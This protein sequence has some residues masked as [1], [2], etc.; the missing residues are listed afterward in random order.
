MQAATLLL[1]DSQIRN[2][3]SKFILAH[4][5]LCTGIFSMLQEQTIRIDT[6]IVRYIQM[7][8]YTHTHNLYI[9]MYEERQIPT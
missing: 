3:Y 2:A 1:N 8:R 9:Y 6:D 5:R 7:Y 4:I